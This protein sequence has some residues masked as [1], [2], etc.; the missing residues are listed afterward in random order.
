MT[1][2]LISS[3]LTVLP[4]FNGLVQT[5]NSEYNILVSPSSPAPSPSTSEIDVISIYSDSYSD[6]P[7]TN[8]Y[9]NWNQ[10]TSVSEVDIN[11][12]KTLKYS[13]FNYQG[14]ELGS[15][16]DASQ[17][18]YIHIDIWTEDATALNFELIS[19]GPSI[20]THALSISNGNWLSFDIPLTSF[21]GQVDIKEIFQACFQ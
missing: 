7:N 20:S 21:N 11:G 2:F 17:M 5:N 14:I 3:L 9:A 13:N 16:I 19:P 18:E 8:F 1:I 4:I 12:N 10:S 15:S 6:I